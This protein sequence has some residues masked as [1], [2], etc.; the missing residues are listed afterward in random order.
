MSKAH[1]PHRLKVH[2]PTHPI[3][4]PRSEIIPSAIFTG[5]QQIVMAARLSSF[6]YLLMGLFYP[7]TAPIA[8][9]LDKWLGGHHTFKRYTREEVRTM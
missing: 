1:A 3:P 7:I 4:R 2:L 9:V 8:W 5:P 6:V